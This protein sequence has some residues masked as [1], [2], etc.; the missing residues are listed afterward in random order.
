M[1]I[2]DLEAYMEGEKMIRFSLKFPPHPDL[3]GIYL[4]LICY[5]HS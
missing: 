2:I 5:T 3:R 4:H 1:L